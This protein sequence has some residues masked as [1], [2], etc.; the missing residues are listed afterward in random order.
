MITTGAGGAE[1]ASYGGGGGGFGGA[2]GGGGGG[3]G[4][5]EQ[6]VSANDRVTTSTD[7]VR[8]AE[9]KLAADRANPKKKPE[10]IAKDEDEVAEAKRKLA[11]AT[12]HLQDIQDAP[13]K[14]PRGEGREGRG[15]KDNRD[16]FAGA[17]GDTAMKAFTDNIPP[18]FSNPLEWSGTKSISA[19]FKFFG[20]LL[21]GQGGEAAKSLIG[22]GSGAGYG[23]G[24]GGGTVSP[25]VQSLMAQVPGFTGSG[26]NTNIVNQT[27][28][29]NGDVTNGE[30]FIQG[31]EAA[32][33]RTA[34]K[35]LGTLALTP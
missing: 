20:N 9:A 1:S 22:D 32:D 5:P 31:K 2:G 30:G 13:P 17:F 27:S 11:E 3:G 18:G 16:Q 23:A 29:H 21:G 25:Y 15:G 28:I 19:L 14:E 33:R 4:T 6:L 10:Q 26:G 8:E 24:Y 12:Q 35:T 34:L 7:K